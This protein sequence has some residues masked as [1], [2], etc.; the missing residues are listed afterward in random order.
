MFSD[1]F[2]NIKLG[3]FNDLVKLRTFKAVK[4]GKCKLRTMKTFKDPYEP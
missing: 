3:T 4:I 1:D 2:T